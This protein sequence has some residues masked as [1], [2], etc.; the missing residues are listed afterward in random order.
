MQT[1][2]TIHPPLNEHQ[3]ILFPLLQAKVGD[4]FGLYM[5]SV[6]G[7]FYPNE[8]E[9]YSG[10][11][12]TPNDEHFFFWTSWDYEKERVYLGTWEPTEPMDNYCEADVYVEL[13]R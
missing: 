2:K 4:R 7:A 3:A 6:E 5:T 13:G 11:V 1:L 12:V 8:F 10:Y 9:E